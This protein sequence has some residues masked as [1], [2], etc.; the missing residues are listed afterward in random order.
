MEGEYRGGRGIWSMEVE[1]EYRVQR[2]I[3]KLK[4]NMEVKG[5]YGG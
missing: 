4:G 5:E 1:G 3:K 2:E